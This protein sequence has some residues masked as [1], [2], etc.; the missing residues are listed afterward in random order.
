M[1]FLASKSPRRR[2][3]LEQIGV[4]FD[5][6]DVDIPEV[7]AVDEPALDYVSRV[8]REKAGAG[9]LQVAGVP[10]AVVIGADTEVVLDGE[11][12]GKPGHAE[13]AAAM[14]GRLAGRTHSVIS[15]VWCVSAAREDHVISV[16]EVSIAALDGRSIDAYVGTGEPF[17]K[18][19]GY[20]IQG[21]A[22][23]FVQHL[24][25]SYSGVMGLPLHETS[26]LL[27]RFPPHSAVQDPV[28]AL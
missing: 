10:A 25:G 2:Q 19:G 20:A 4:A 24:N 14:L 27:A 12:F 22:A 18:A 15:V 9:L 28:R 5:V 6:L 3:L 26:Q 23:A 1:Y 21:R 7:R 13:D 11:V 8:A 17:G 16:S